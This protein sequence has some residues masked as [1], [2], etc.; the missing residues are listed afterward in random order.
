MTE[1]EKV[2][3]ECLLALEHG[4][5]NV[6][7]C[8]S[9]YP[10]YALQLEPVL[11]TSLDLEYGREARPSAAFKARVRAKLT[12]E[13]Q[14]HPRKSIRFNFMFIRMATNF[15]VLLLALLIAGTAYAQSTLPGNP[16]YAW[17][18]ASENVWRIVSP[19]PIGTD[20]AIAGR[21]AEELI[22]IGNNSVQR[23]QI[24]EAYLEVVSRLRLEMN[25]DNEARIQ[26]VLDTQI[27]E[28]NKSG[29]IVPQLDQ[30]QNVLPGLEQPAPIPTET[31]LVT[32]IVTPQLPQVNP[33]L[34]I[35]TVD[36]VLTQDAP[37]ENL[38]DLPKIV[39][40]VQVPSLIP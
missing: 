29:V 5:S 21:R 14:A 33:T 12:R 25:A 9:R 15:A 18:L 23:T 32:P 27:E 1:F 37:Q 34:P 4:D 20:L 8:L 6:D 35:P 40:T 39:P 10:N 38:T 7:E 3:Q 13:M 17:K 16:F 19:D 11:L 26:S 28:L 36:S 2:L 24:L 30:N 22:A 31:P